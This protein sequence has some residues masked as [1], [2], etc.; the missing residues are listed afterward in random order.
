M[1]EKGPQGRF[2][3]PTE[4]NLIESSTLVETWLQTPVVPYGTRVTRSEPV[5]QR[6]IGQFLTVI[7]EGLV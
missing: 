2:Q 3:D 1:E 4:N 6:G 5:H 7:W